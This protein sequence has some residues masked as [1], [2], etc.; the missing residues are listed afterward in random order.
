MRLLNYF[1]GIVVFSLCLAFSV[2]SLAQKKGGSFLGVGGGITT[3]TQT[4]I[5]NY[6]T[7]LANNSKDA[8]TALEGYGQYGYRINGSMIALIF[9]PSYFSQSASGTAKAS[10][11]GYTAFPMLRLYPLENKFM[12]FMIQFGAGYGSLSGKIDNGSSTVSFKGAAFGA[13]AGLG[14]DFCIT[15][16]HCISVEGNLRYLPIMQNIVSNTS[17]N[18]GGTIGTPIN[19]GELEY[20]ATGAASDTNVTTNMGGIT[21]LVGYA[22]YF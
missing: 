8:G 19:S 10:L 20:T 13:Q 14:A 16:H 5:N 1:F 18:M 3:A 2:P 11:T 6:F 12:K 15:D 7:S 4:D 22:Y 17:G 9:R 21:A